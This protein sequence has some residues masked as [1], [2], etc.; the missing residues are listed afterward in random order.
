MDSAALDQL[1]AGAG[2]VAGVALLKEAQDMAA[3]QAAQLVQTLPSPASLP[4]IGEQLDL[5]V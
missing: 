3:L 2:G 4:G 5:V 1:A